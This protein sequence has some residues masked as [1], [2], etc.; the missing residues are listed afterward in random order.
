MAGAARLIM[1]FLLAGLGVRGVRPGDVDQDGDGLSPRR[2]GC[3]IDC[4]KPGTSTFASS[5]CYN[6]KLESDGKTCTSY[7]AKETKY[8]LITEKFEDYE[9]CECTERK[10]YAQEEI[11]TKTYL[12][13]IQWKA[14]TGGQAGDRQ[15]KKTTCAS[16]KDIVFTLQKQ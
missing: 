13:T 5:K 10:V 12:S 8:T 11:N 4:C 2:V 7:A 14:P 3:T 9:A 6:N 15:D 1:L 16:D